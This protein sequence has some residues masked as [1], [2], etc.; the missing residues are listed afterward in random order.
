MDISLQQVEY[1]YQANTP[2]ERLALKNVSFDIPE[3]TYL[4]IIGHTG[5]GKSTVLQ[6]LN[7]LLKPTKGKIVIGDTE[8]TAGQKQKKLKK[9]RQRVGIVFQFPEHQLF[10]ETIEK[11]ICFGPMNFGVTEEEAKRRAKEVIK[12]VGLSED[13]LQKSP[14]DLSGGQMRR[15]AI[16]GVLAMEPDVI[17]LDEP[18]AGLDPRGRKEIMNMFYSLHKEKKLSTILVTHSM[19]DAARYADQIIVM[20]K[21]EV[22]KKGT[23]EEIFAAPEGL[24]E[25][26]LDVPEVI[27]F[28]KSFE[29]TCQVKLDR[30]CLTTEQLAESVAECMKRGVPK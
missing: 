7:A 26:G 14:F 28:Q 22:Y 3:G 8:I 15:V 24:M 17:V 9:V 12:Q 1:R 6:H 20:H 5:S 19:E 27:R 4:A 23:P 10:E 30:I 18:T 25:L 11:D 16:A 2:F 29:E 13:F 21:G